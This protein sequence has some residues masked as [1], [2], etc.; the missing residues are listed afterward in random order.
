[1]PNIAVQ[2]G[3]QGLSGM[4]EGLSVM[5]ACSAGV[6][7]DLTSGALLCHYRPSWLSC[8]L[9]QLLPFL[10]HWMLVILTFAYL[11][12]AK[13]IVVVGVAHA[14]LIERGLEH[15]AIGVATVAIFVH[16]I[17]ILAPIVDAHRECR[18]RLWPPLPV[19]HMWLGGL[20]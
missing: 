11:V 1:M 7:D 14:M 10:P 20:F 16:L 8:Y 5:A 9:F 6:C 18:L 4:A 2:W 19:N 13:L 15:V 3:M 17:A 12:Q